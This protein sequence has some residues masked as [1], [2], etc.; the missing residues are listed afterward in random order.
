MPAGGGRPARW[1]EEKTDMPAQ[2]TCT[3]AADFVFD[4]QVQITCTV[5]SQVIEEAVRDVADA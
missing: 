1:Q 5:C 2:M 3:A 4:V